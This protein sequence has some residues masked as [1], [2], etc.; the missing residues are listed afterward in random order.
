MTRQKRSTRISP[1]VVHCRQVSCRQRMLWGGC[2]DWMSG[3]RWFSYNTCQS[4]KQ[5]NKAISQSDKQK[6]CRYPVY[7]LAH[8]QAARTHARTHTHTHTHTHARFHGNLRHS[9]CQVHQPVG[10]LWSRG[11]RPST[12]NN[13]HHPKLLFRHR[14]TTPTCWHRQ[15]Q[16]VSDLPRTCCSKWQG[17]KQFWKSCANQVCRT[18][19][20][21]NQWRK[22]AL[23]RV[24]LPTA[25]VHSSSRS[26][27]RRT[28]ID[29]DVLSL[30]RVI[31]RMSTA[32]HTQAITHV[33]TVPHT[34]AIT[35]ASTVPH[36]QAI[37]RT[38]TV[39][40]TQAITRTSTAPCTQA[41]TRTSMAPDTYA[42]RCQ[43]APT[44]RCPVHPRFDRSRSH[45]TPS[46]HK[47]VVYCVV[48]VKW[49][50]RSK[51]RLTDGTHSG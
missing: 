43:N 25:V 35:D 14:A 22:W 4:S 3:L 31:A 15:I 23:G 48:V 24:P 42:I 39:P 51:A 18:T 13:G 45:S 47:S 11:E 37:T 29:D 2:N 30:A 10:K 16:R 46:A 49:G 21:S 34:Q 38:S 12:W 36:T 28:A 33:S 50:F 32:P 27:Q 40:H 8:T 6:K 5:I 41:I 26:I 7:R 1:V 20:E 9:N 17:E 19:A 44:T